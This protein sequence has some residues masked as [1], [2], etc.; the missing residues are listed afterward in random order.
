MNIDFD[1]ALRE[2]AR[3]PTVHNV[4]SARW[5]LVDNRVLLLHATAR[6]LPVAD[7]SGRD[8]R[9]SLGAAFEGLALALSRQGLRLGDPEP[10]P[11]IDRLPPGHDAIVSATIHPGGYTDPLAGW[12][13]QRRSFRGRFDPVATDALERG[14]APAPD[15][16]LITDRSQIDRFAGLYDAANFGFMRQSAYVKEL[17]GWCRFST[18]DPRWRRDGLTAD[19]LDLSAPARWAASVL[20]RPAVFRCLRWLGVARPVVSERA[21]IHSSSAVVLYCPSRSVDDFAIGRRLYRL[22]LELTAIGLHACPMSALAD[23]PAAAAAACE[24]GDVPPDRR[25]VNAFRVGRVPGVVAESPRLPAAEL[26]V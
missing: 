13:A 11:A 14:L 21:K 6:A 19:C 1:A 25:L 20:L 9:A 7:P 18:R 8:S 22:W 2:A 23:A 24:I 3:A 5:R 12:V 17:Y 15:V 26:L 4:Q 10:A 16:R